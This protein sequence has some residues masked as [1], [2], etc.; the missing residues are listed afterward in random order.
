MQCK[1]EDLDSKLKG[2]I[3]ASINATL[4]D[5][6]SEPGTIIIEG[7]IEGASCDRLISLVYTCIKRIAAKTDQPVTSITETLSFLAE[8]NL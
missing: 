3:P 4:A 5:N 2:E 8:N 1:N 6:P 7:H